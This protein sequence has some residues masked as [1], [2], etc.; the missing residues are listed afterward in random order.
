[1]RGAGVSGATMD[2]VLAWNGPT[3]AICVAFS[4]KAT[5]DC[6]Q[7][8]KRV[9]EYKAAPWGVRIYDPEKSPEGDQADEHPLKPVE[10]ASGDLRSHGSPM[11]IR[12]GRPATGSI[13][14]EDPETK[15]KPIGVKVTKANGKRTI[16]KFDP[17]TTPEDARLLAPVIADRARHASPLG[18]E[19]VGE[20][21][22]RWVAE[23]KARGIS[24]W[25]HDRGRLNGHV[26]PLLGALDVRT[27]R[28]ED[29]ERVVEDLDRK[30][31]LDEEDDEEH[32]SW[33]TASNVWVLLSKMCKEMSNAKRKDLRVRED[34]PAALVRP[35]ERGEK[36][37]KQYL[38]PSEFRRLVECKEIDAAYRALYAFAVYTYA[39]SNEIA[40]L[41][42]EDIDLEHWTIHI[43]K[44]IDRAT[45]KA[46]P[47][48]TGIT[49][50][51]PI[52]LALRPLLAML[53][54]AHQK[55]KGKKSAPVVWMPDHED[56]A[57]LLREHLETA[58]VKRSELL[59]SNAHRPRLTFHDLRATGITW[60]AVR[61]DNPM[62]I[63]Q[64]AGHK[65]FA[66]TEV[67]IREAENLRQGFGEPFPPLP[68][69]L[70]VSSSVSAFRHRI[71]HGAAKFAWYGVEQ[72]GIEFSRVHNANWATFLLFSSNRSIFRSFR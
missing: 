14:W 47:T 53:R 62:Q 6:Y 40:A 21:A 46:K 65:G 18:V 49:R 30:I 63:K 61:G 50:R 10:A 60:A 24:T 34:N 20:Y 1:M 33:K 22:T 28:R 45:H 8:R 69:E 57:I 41:T 9:I 43:T 12:G 48:K 37:A 19:T 52:E 7:P 15:T 64:R 58:E 23:R 55:A 29:V 35:P 3:A 51:I 17:G 68:S 32:L 16:V 59:T 27:F 2:Y 66:T 4:D 71:P 70:R 11:T 38:Y 44:S 5:A 13:I 25:R 26:L 54:S 39:C 42:W 67:Y 31:S 72:R 56:R 36:K